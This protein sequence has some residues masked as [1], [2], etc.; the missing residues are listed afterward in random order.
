MRADLETNKFSIHPDG[1]AFKLRH[2]TQLKLWGLE[3]KDGIYTLETNS[4]NENKIITVLEY[5]NKHNFDV[6]LSN[7]CKEFIKIFSNKNTRYKEIL[8]YLRNYKDGDISI[9]ALEEHKNFLK[10]LKRTLKDHQIKSSLHL[11]LASNA[12]NFSVPGS[13]KTTVVLSVYQRLKDEGKVDALFVIGPPSCFGPW[14]DEFMEVIGRM[15]SVNIFAGGHIATRKENY[16]KKDFSE[17][18][19]TSFH[20]V[21]RDYNDLISFLKNTRTM[22]VVDEAHYIKQ[23]GGEWA[24]SVLSVSEF[25]EKRVILTGTPMPRSY[26]DLYNIFEFLYPDYELISSSDKIAISNYEKN[27]RYLDAQKLIEEKV[28]P[29]FYRVRKSELGLAEQVFNDPIEIEMNEHERKIYDAIITRII[30]YSRSDYYKNIDYVTQLIRGRMIRLRQCISNTALLSNTIDEYDE[31]LLD[32]DSNLKKLIFKYS[33]LEKPA[34]LIKLLDMVKHFIGK[35]EKILIWSNFIGTIKLIE[36]EL[37]SNNIYSKKIIGE[38]PVEN[39]DLKEAETREDIRNEFVDADS[40]LMVLLANPAACAE[41]IS[42]HKSCN[43]AVYYDLSYN[44]AQFLQS[45]DR[46]HRVGGSENKK[47]YYYFLQYTDTI[48]QDIL[49]NI[50]L[51]AEKMRAVIENDYSIYSLDMSDISDEIEAYKKLT[52]TE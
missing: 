26:M 49:E 32:K 20:T 28:G 5:L 35:N 24:N 39:N 12:A 4:S 51:K 22:L 16:Y 8:E 1:D 31:D 52:H 25:A 46:I 3:N 19:L 47:S 50:E 15:P 44:C 33:E 2:K 43:H 13:G 11:Y 27:N 30:H 36:S 6:N 18:N 14:K 29:L 37:K 10:T 21:R 48:D 23:V 9:S 40:E 38:T 42:L 34:K 7:S 41:S 17:L 45:L